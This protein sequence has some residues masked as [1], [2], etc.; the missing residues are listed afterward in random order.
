MISEI[1]WKQAS[2]A[3]NTAETRVQKGAVK[4]QYLST[5]EQ[6]ADILPEWPC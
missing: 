1:S 3:L 5:D 4:L 2:V 6:I